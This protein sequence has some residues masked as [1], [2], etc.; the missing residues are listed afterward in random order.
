MAQLIGYQDGIDWFVGF[1]R[2]IP[3]VK[4]RPVDQRPNTLAQWYGLEKFERTLRILKDDHDAAIVT[5]PDPPPPPPPPPPS[6]PRLAP[7]THYK[8]GGAD[9]RYCVRSPGVTQIAPDHYRDEGGFTYSENGLCDGGRSGKYV[10]GLKGAD[11]MD[12]RE[13]CDGYTFNGVTFPPWPAASY[14][15]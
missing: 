9:A 4:Y 10:P 11:S 3:G 8:A 13:P 15:V 14:E 6:A 7:M 5:T 1:A 2:K 12:G